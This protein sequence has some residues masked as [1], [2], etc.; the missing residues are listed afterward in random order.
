MDW[1]LLDR[2][3][4]LSPIA[5]PNRLVAAAVNRQKSDTVFS[6]TPAVD[7][8]E[9]C[10]QFFFGMDTHVVDVYPMKK[11]SDFASTLEDV[12][13]ERGAPTR[14]IS[15]SANEETRGKA[16]D[17]LRALYIGSWQ[18]EPHQQHQNPAERRFQTVKNTTNVILDRT[19]APPNTWLLCLLYVCFLLNHTFCNAI[20]GIPMTALT[21]QTPDI[22]PL[23]RFHFWEEVYYKLDDSDFPSESRELKGNIVGIAENVGHLMTYKV[24]TQDTQKIICRSNLRPVQPGLMNKRLDLLSGEDLKLPTNPVLKSRHDFP[25]EPGEQP[26]EEAKPAETPVIIP[27][28]LIGRTFLMEP[29]EDGQ[30]FRARIVQCIEDHENQL[31]KNTDR[32]K[33]KCSIN[34][35]EFEDILSYDQVLEHITRDEQTTIA[36]K[37]KRI[38]AHQG[39]LTETH[40][41]YSGSKWNVRV[42]WENGEIT[43]EPL[44]TIA[45]DDPVTC[46]IYAKDN[47][48]LHLDGWKRFKSIARRHKKYLRMVKQA[49]LRS[50][51]TAPKYM[52]GYEIP[53]NYKHALE[54]DAR[55]G[56]TKW[57]DCTR[58]E[59]QQL[60]EYS[61]FKDLGRASSLRVPDGFKKIRVH[62]VYAVKHD[63]RH[64]ARLVA[65]G[66]LTDV[67]MESVYSGVVSLRGF[68]LVI[69]LAELNGLEVWAT[70][71]G[72]AYLE[73][74]T[75]EKLVIVA[76]P[77]FG[78]L[79][80]HLLQIDRALYGLRTSGLRWHER[81]SQCLRDLGFAPCKAEPDIW[82][83]ENDGLYE[84]V[85]VYVDDLALAMRAPQ[86]FVDT[87]ITKY[88]F[89]LKGTGP[90]AY[91]LGMNFSRDPDGTLTLAPK[92]YIERMI[93]TYKRLYGESP[94][95][96]YHSPLE[97]GDHPELDGS[98]L[99]DQE[100]ISQYQSLIGTLQWVI[101][102]GRFDVQTAVMTLSSFRAAPR[103]GHLKRAKRIFGYL[104]KMRNA[105]I[106]V[107]TLIPDFSELPDQKFDWTSS[108]YGDPKELTPHD[109]P[110][111][112]GKPVV[113]VSFVD[114][115]LMH[116]LL[117]GRSVT[118]ILHFINQT[119]FDWFSKKQSTVET[120]TY[121]SEFVAART[122]V[123]QIIDHRITLR[124]LGVPIKESYL[125]GDND[126]VVNSSTIP[127]AKL[128]KRHTMLSFHRVREAIASSIM[129]FHHIAGTSNCADIL[130]KH[131]GYSQIWHLLKPILFWPDT[132]VTTEHNPVDQQE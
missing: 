40:P 48:L 17:I 128:H 5:I 96:S 11:K 70:D 31:E 103:R 76:G 37:F 85:A 4:L 77:E 1:I 66:H 113:T 8:G 57:Q 90:I 3:P 106:R 119:P 97:K 108:V 122:A 65:D 32:I 14:L 84:Y 60:N 53:R 92:K 109:A 26:S 20:N 43:S 19:G 61:T 10:A 100:G 23:L 46:A 16:Q 21:G 105:A 125:F 9:T 118:G 63:G 80:G 116:D 58:L 120:A 34:N 104:A 55:N 59:M 114:A 28:D 98:E 102:I 87:L 49:K 56:N 2:T 42:E 69:F 131:W 99:L 83:R 51:S 13:R 35:D 18:S 45:A 95:E 30:R 107:R 67:P 91:H 79:E 33:F 123:E 94:D 44:S 62:L 124:Y 7:G 126:S 101:T 112:L 6:D 127:H 72:N 129:S 71:I 86:Q 75:K 110:K 89:K 93:D 117:T 82:M 64:K 36:W 73:A 115:N 121:G 29:R 47:N 78:E 68:R 12:I 81:F 41:D 132:I 88:G 22:S 111:P 54:L 39:P 27:N 15:D 24:L 38:V 50:Y 25:P 52:F 130:S 74:K